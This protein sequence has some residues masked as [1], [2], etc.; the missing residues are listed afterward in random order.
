MLVSV[1]RASR[2]PVAWVSIFSRW[3][4]IQEVVDSFSEF[5]QLVGLSKLYAAGEVLF[6]NG[7]LQVHAQVIDRPYVFVSKGKTQKYNLNDNK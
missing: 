3:F 2:L 7:F 6:F 5:V 1:A 4:V